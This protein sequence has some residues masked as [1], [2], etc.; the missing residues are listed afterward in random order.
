[1]IFDALVIGGQTMAMSMG[2]GFAMMVDPPARR[3]GAGGQPV[4]LIML[5]RW[6][7]SR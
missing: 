4:L 5:A 7:S 1:M 2:L 3:L 6:C